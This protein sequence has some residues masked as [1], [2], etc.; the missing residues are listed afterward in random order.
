ME[1]KSKRER[2]VRSMDAYEFGVMING[3]WV[4]YGYDSDTQTLHLFGGEFSVTFPEN[5]FGKFSRKQAEQDL[6]ENY[7]K[8]KYENLDFTYRAW[9]Y[10][11]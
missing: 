6:V 11:D 7:E 10:Y 2:L 4:Q 9:G 3:E 5:K 8:Y 1:L